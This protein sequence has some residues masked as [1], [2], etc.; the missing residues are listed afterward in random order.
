M[1]IVTFKQKFNTVALIALLLMVCALLLI[2]DHIVVGAIVALVGATVAVLD[3]HAF[4]RWQR[5][6]RDRNGID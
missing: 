6:E 5:R 2:Q 4:E 1:E 3:V